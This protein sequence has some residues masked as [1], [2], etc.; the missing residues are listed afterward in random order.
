[1]LGIELGV[2]PVDLSCWRAA[3]PCDSNVHLSEHKLALFEETQSSI[4]N[5]LEKNKN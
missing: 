4:K 2:R 3:S 5:I 1:M